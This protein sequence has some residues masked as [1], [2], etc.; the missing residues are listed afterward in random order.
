MDSIEHLRALLL[1][2]TPGP[3]VAHE[4]YGPVWVVSAELPT[5]GHSPKDYTAIT[6]MVYGGVAN[7][8]LIVSAVNSLPGIL[9]E[10]ERVRAAL[11]DLVDGIDFAGGA[12]LAAKDLRSRYDIARAALG[13]SS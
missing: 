12:A 8:A 3:W 4:Q 7:A 10:L 11:R 5:D 9:E 13:V 1:A 2:A 6:D